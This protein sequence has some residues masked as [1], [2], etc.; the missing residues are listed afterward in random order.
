MRSRWQRWKREKGTGVVTVCSFSG[1]QSHMT[2]W[3]A[4]SVYYDFYQVIDNNGLKLNLRLF[5]KNVS[6]KKKSH[7][8][9]PYHF[10]TTST[11]SLSLNIHAQIVEYLLTHIY[12]HINNPRSI[13]SIIKVCVVDIKRASTDGLWVCALSALR[14]NWSL[15]QLSLCERQ[16]THRTSHLFNKGMTYRNKHSPS[17]S[18]LG[19]N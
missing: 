4:M 10:T 2:V 18:H 7:L 13:N 11:F 9:S 1:S 15:S 5:C 8:T 12:L 16:G 14:P 19:A 6:N 3:K 17:H